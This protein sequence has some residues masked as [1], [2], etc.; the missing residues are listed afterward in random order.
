MVSQDRAIAGIGWPELA[1][2]DTLPPSGRGCSDGPP[3]GGGNSGN[4]GGQERKSEFEQWKSNSSPLL[5]CR[6]RTLPAPLEGFTNEERRQK[7]EVT[8]PT[9]LRKPV[10]EL[11]IES[12]S[13]CP[14]S[15]F[16]LNHYPVKSPA[17][18]E[19]FIPPLCQALHPLSVLRGTLKGKE[20]GRVS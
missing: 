12:R 18:A 14:S 8:C 11:R 3:P 13:P 4:G 1:L 2:S 10:A 5:V 6:H 15:S 20:A 17:G 16:L 19:A 9:S 7:D